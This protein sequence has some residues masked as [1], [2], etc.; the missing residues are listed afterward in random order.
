MLEEWIT[1]ALVKGQ[2][3]ENCWRNT[4]IGLRRLVQRAHRVHFRHRRLHE[5]MEAMV[6]ERQSPNLPVHGERQHP[7]P[8]T[9]L[10]IIIDR[11]KVELQSLILPCDNLLLEL[12][13]WQILKEQ[14]RW[15]VWR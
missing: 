4:R 14:R 11:S 12:R 1:E 9:N 15:R 2:W 6:D 3:S 7:L 13:G 5:G 8:H 10:P